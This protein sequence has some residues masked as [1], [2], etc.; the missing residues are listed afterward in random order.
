MVLISY[1]I[2]CNPTH[3]YSQDIHLID[4][5]DT[6]VESVTL[7][8]I[9]Y[10]SDNETVMSP[11]LICTSGQND[12]SYT[13][14]MNSNEHRISSKHSLTKPEICNFWEG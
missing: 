11:D 7:Q 4:N 12:Q 13:A 10:N 1:A 2:S 3:P 5:I 6:I 14:L 8:A 9:T